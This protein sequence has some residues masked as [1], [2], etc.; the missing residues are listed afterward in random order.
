[1]TDNKPYSNEEVC[2]LVYHLYNAN[3]LKLCIFQVEILQQ[4][5]FYHRKSWRENLSHIQYYFNPNPTK[6]STVPFIQ[7]LSNTWALQAVSIRVIPL[8]PLSHPKVSS[9][10][11][12]IIRYMFPTFCAKQMIPLTIN[13]LNKRENIFTW[14]CALS[15]W[16]RRMW[17]L[18]TN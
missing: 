10:T 16:Y 4:R 11:Q 14:P 6:V 2:N 3:L 5:F 9:L 18:R 8:Q 13:E 12:E 7:Y 17:C 15:P 1:M